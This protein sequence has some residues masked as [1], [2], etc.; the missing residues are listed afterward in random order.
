MNKKTETLG[1]GNYFGGMGNVGFLWSYL[2]YFEKKLEAEIVPYKK[3]SP[4][5][6]L[7]CPNFAAWLRIYTE[8]ICNKLLTE[9]HRADKLQKK[10]NTYQFREMVEKIIRITER[11]IATNKIKKNEFAKLKKAIKMVVELRH[12]LQHGGIPNILRDIKYKNDIDEEDINKMG[13]PQN[14]KETKRIFYD[15]NRLIDL[16]P[17]PTIR[18]YKNGSIKIN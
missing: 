14:Y 12:T 5:A 8:L 2:K 4:P 16:L 11:K 9:I 17:K 15:A 3:I 6:Y 13:V 1:V 10:I 18:A 7:A